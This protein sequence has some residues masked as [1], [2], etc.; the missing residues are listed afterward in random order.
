MDEL[1]FDKLYRIATGK[2]K[3]VVKRVKEIFGKF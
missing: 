2:Q 3:V 1:M